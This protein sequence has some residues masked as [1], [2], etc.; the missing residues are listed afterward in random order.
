MATIIKIKIVPCRECAFFFFFN[1]IKCAGKHTI[2]YY[3]VNNNN[4][5]G[6]Q[7]TL[8]QTAIFSGSIIIRKQCRKIST[9]QVID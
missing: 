7:L 1:Q 3:S 9:D 8:L 5:I 4:C 2:Q 6:L